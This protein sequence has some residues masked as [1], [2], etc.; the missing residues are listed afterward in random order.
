MSCPSGKNG[1]YSREL[2]IEALI[3]NHIRSG[4]KKGSG[5][6]NVYDCADCGEWHFTSRT[7]TAEELLDP[8]TVAFITRERNAMEWERKLR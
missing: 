6:Q 7:P 4:H 1:F 2:A 5:P 8:E 3:Q